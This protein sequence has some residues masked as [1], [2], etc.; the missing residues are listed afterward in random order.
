MFKE[1]LKG[2]S[3]A[4]SLMGPSA[5]KGRVLTRFATASSPP[6][7]TN[8]LESPAVFNQF[9]LSR[10]RISYSVFKSSVKL[11]RVKKPLQQILFRLKIQKMPARKVPAL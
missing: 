6:S 10:V 2:F 4:L 1:G 8:P 3:L 5:E 11:H 9:R 7:K